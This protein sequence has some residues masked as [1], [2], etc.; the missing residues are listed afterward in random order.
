MTDSNTGIS[1][2]RE[3]MAL[4]GMSANDDL[5]DVIAMALLR[6]KRLNVQCGVEDG[7]MPELWKDGYSV[8]FEAAK[9]LFQA[10]PEQQPLQGWH[11]AI[12][13]LMDF[14][15][16]KRAQP[17]GMNRGGPYVLKAQ[18]IEVLERLAAA[19]VGGTK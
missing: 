4:L 13:D 8:G 5:H 19:P 7:I 18:V 15:P 17:D 9:A 11:A 6:I 14:A 2:Y 3:L 1:P 16:D 10:Q 12:E